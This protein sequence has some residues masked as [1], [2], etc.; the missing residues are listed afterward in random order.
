R[1]HAALASFGAADHYEAAE[2]VNPA[3]ATTETGEAA[4]EPVSTNDTSAT[5][6]PRSSPPSVSSAWMVE[7]IDLDTVLTDVPDIEATSTT[8][9]QNGSGSNLLERMSD[10]RSLGGR[11]RG[12]VHQ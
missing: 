12:G 1:R 11:R 2:P 9:S 6:Q 10:D 5:L 7:A 8:G 4:H 3:D